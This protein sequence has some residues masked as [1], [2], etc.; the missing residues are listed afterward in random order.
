MRIACLIAVA[1]LL[2]LPGIARAEVV[3]A[4]HVTVLGDNDTRAQARRVCLLEAKRRLLEQAGTYIEASTEVDRFAVTRDEVR[5]FASAILAVDIVE[6][7]YFVTAEG[8]YAVRMKVRAD[9]DP[10]DIRRRLERAVADPDTWRRMNARAR[11]VRSL[12]DEALDLQ[13]RMGPDDDPDLANRLA[14]ARIFRSLEEIEE[15]GREI[16]A[17]VDRVS[18]LAEKVAVKG[19]TPAEVER[20]LGPPRAVKANRAGSVA[21]ECR[22]YGRMWLVFRD[23]LLACKRTRLRYQSRYGGDCHCAGMVGEV[24]TE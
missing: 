15:E 24:F 2:A 9:I 11:R 22:N 20:L 1:V 18:E 7:R 5:T 3:E 6:E 10:V 16:M 17:E 8:Q 19:M 21:Y 12:E 4:E 14:Q 13:R 23:G